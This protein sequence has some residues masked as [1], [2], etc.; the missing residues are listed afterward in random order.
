MR[1]TDAIVEQVKT[2]FLNRI[3]DLPNSEVQIVLEDLIQY[4]GDAL[5]KVQEAR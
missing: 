5:E 4:F 3:L 2:E 1:D